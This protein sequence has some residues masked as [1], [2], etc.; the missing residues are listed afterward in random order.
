MELPRPRTA[1]RRGS[2]CMSTRRR[3]D[4][5]LVR[6]GLARSREHAAELVTAGRVV[7][8][9]QSAG[10]T[11]TQ[12]TADDPIAVQDAGPARSTRPGAG[13]NSQARWPPSP[14]CPWRATLRGR[15]RVHRRLHGGPAGAGAARS[16][17][18]TSAMGSSCAVARRP[19]HERTGPPCGPDP[20]QAAPPPTL[21]TARPVV[22]LAQPRAAAL[23]RGAAPDARPRAAREAA[24]RGRAR[25]L[26]GAGGSCATPRPG[27]GR[28]RGGRGRRDNGL[29]VDGV[30]RQ[31][32]PRPR[33]QRGVL[34]LAAP[35][36]GAAGAGRDSRGHARKDRQ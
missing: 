9:G 36:C 29:D 10:K 3:L 30:D 7:V 18:W 33:R 21:V 12:V 4:A 22:H 31:P 27:R 1:E 6:R 24:V 16:S 11:A 35:R 5:E 19:G 26:V 15:G 23:I 17:P 20:A 28:V 13:A 25:R 14:D 34:P 32:A 8:A 2:H